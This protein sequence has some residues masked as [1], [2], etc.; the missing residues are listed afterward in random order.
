MKSY[1]LHAI[2]KKY[3]LLLCLWKNVAILPGVCE[4]TPEEDVRSVAAVDKVLVVVVADETPS[5]ESPLDMSFFLTWLRFLRGLRLVFVGDSSSSVFATSLPA[6]LGG[7]RE[8]LRRLV[9]LPLRDLLPV[10]SSSE[11]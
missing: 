11:T 8:L 4:E 5:S 6:L 1:K 7:C 9:G 3:P 10:S 2:P